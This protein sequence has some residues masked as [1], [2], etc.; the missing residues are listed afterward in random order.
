MTDGSPSLAGTG[1]AATVE[2]DRWAERIANARCALVRARASR[3][4]TSASVLA[5][6]IFSR[7]LRTFDT[8]NS[9]PRTHNPPGNQPA[10]MS[11]GLSAGLSKRMQAT[12]LIPASAT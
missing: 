8:N 11:R 1:T 10:G 6:E 9:S 12:A 4:A 5:G 2:F 3:A 7:P